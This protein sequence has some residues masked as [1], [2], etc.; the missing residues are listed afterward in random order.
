VADAER[1]HDLGGQRDQEITAKLAAQNLA[2][3]LRL[4]LQAG[5]PSHPVPG[6]PR[7]TTSPTCNGGSGR[8]ERRGRPHRPDHG[9]SLGVVTT[10]VRAAGRGDPVDAHLGPRRCSHVFTFTTSY[11]YDTLEPGADADLP[12]R[13]GL[14]L[15]LQLR[16]AGRTAPPASGGRHHLPVRAPAGVRR[17][18]RADGRCWTPATVPAPVQATTRPQAT[19]GRHQRATGAG[20]T[21]SRTHIK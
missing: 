18:V 10:G 3:D 2:I 20:G 21:C 15:P 19:A 6:V 11:S 1:L 13:R 7:P 8:A 4:R 14:V 5:R 9:W 16:R 17:Q 12:G